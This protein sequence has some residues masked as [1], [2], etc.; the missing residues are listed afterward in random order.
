MNYSFETVRKK[1]DKFI[2]Y[3]NWYHIETDIIVV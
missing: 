3:T 1:H 2:R